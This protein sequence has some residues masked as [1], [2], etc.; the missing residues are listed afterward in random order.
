MALWFSNYPP[1][2]APYYPCRLAVSCFLWIWPK[3]TM[4]RAKNMDFGFFHPPG[5]SSSSDC[6]KHSCPCIP[7]P[8]LE[9]LSALS[10]NRKISWLGLCS[11]FE[12]LHP[13]PAPLSL[14]RDQPTGLLHKLHLSLSWSYLTLAYIA[15]PL[16]L[17]REAFFRCPSQTLDLHFMPVLHTHVPHTALQQAE[18]GRALG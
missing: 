15:P 11:G 8:Y 13:S 4:K 6:S 12:G 16:P 3:F 18:R 14:K 10:K 7:P 2:G 1:T 5:S 17:L 9:T